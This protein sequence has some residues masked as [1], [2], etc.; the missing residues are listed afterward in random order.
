MTLFA[1]HF[2][3]QPKYSQHQRAGE[4]H[5]TLFL[6]SFNTMR[7][8]QET[9]TPWRH[10]WVIIEEEFIIDVTYG[11]Q[12]GLIRIVQAEAKLVH[13]RGILEIPFDGHGLQIVAQG[14]VTLISMKCN[15]EN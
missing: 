9:S 10:L 6:L 3:E 12:G 1:R 8:E 11:E 14:R 4:T 15:K 7:R 13:M 5:N 2:T